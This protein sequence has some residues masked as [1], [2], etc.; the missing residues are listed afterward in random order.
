MASIND[1]WWN[2]QPDGSKIRSDRYGTGLRWQV[3]YRNPEG[4]SRNRSFERQVDADRFMASISVDL[5]RGTY[6]DPKSGSIL[7]EEL[8]TK[9]LASRTADS[10]TLVQNELHVRKHMLPYWGGKSASAIKHSDIQTWISDL[11]KV[12]L[13]PKYIRLI[14]INFRLILET[15]VNDE[16][17][18]KNPVN[19]AKLQLPTS[20]KVRVEVW[21]QEQVSRVIAAHPSHLRLMPLLGATCGLRQGEILGLRLQDI[22]FEKL[23]LNVRQQIKLINTKPMPALPKFKRTRVVP[24]PQFVAE[25]ISHFLKSA[26][27]LEGERT[28]S[29]GLGG[30]LFSLRE[31]RPINKNYYNTTYW[32]PAIL[33]AGLSRARSNGTHALRHFCAST[34]LEH[35]VSIRA[36]AEYL[37]H[38]DPG[39]TLRI[40]THLMPKSDDS[41]RSAFQKFAP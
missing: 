23:E 35:G 18:Q 7:F 19:Y 32:H 3:R 26:Q 8:A 17:I 30:I 11:Q 39:F 12:G 2:K 13:S 36:V 40:Y 28:F 16:L 5:H 41:A 29:P 14:F 22:D 37:G 34:W 27:V 6:I 1:R 24:L 25:E 38:S 9:W 10:S 21:T 15:A 33:S 4:K 31:R 20:A